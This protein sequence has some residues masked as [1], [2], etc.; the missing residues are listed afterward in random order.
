MLRAPL[1]PWDQAPSDYE[2][3]FVRGDVWPSFELIAM[4]SDLIAWNMQLATAG[5][6][7]YFCTFSRLA[8]DGLALLEEI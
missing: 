5:N 4:W 1:K 6:A 3:A 2:I 8:N 7:G